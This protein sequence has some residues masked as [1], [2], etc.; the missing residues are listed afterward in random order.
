MANNGT[1]T[2]TFIV[3]LHHVAENERCLWKSCENLHNDSNLQLTVC[4]QTGGLDGIFHAVRAGLLESCKLY[5]VDVLA[6]S[7]AV[8]SSLCL[9]RTR[10]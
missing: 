8:G 9:L 10:K 7:G 3:W 5:A 4:S 1:L 2:Q 6:G